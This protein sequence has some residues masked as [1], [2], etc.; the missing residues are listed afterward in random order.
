MAWRRMLAAAIAAGS[1]LVAAP[2]AMAVVPVVTANMP[3]D[4]A[5]KSATL[6]GRVDPSSLQ[7]TY[8]FEWDVAG[9]DFCNSSPTATAAMRGADGIVE[10]YDGPTSV[11]ETVANLSPETTYCFRVVAHN[12]SGTSMSSRVNF[13][14]PPMPPETALFKKPAGL[15]TTRTVEMGFNS[16]IDGVTF[17]CRTDGA[18]WNACAS[19]FQLT[20]LA[21][22]VHTFEVR[23]I[24][25]RTHL[26]D[27]TPATSTFRVSAGSGTTAGGA[28]GG[29]GTPGTVPPGPTGS[30]PAPVAAAP[31]VGRAG[32][33][34]LKGAKLTTGQKVSC[35]GTGEACRV[36]VKLTGSARGSKKLAKIGAARMTVAAGAS[37]AVVVKL[38][39]K[40]RKLLKKAHALKV[41][42]LV[43]VR[44]GQRIP[45]TAGMKLNVKKK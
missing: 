26:E 3:Q 31:K 4:L 20:D 21:D 17:E 44:R 11:T 32:R 27:E 9:S 38:N 2:A 24:D 12:A 7:T 29:S 1:T 8:H 15:V 30:A 19:P 43:T 22:G 16:S 18:A 33:A 40:G 28:G 36:T 37:K 42:S 39:A 41:V 5:A 45:V 14:T 10:A 25:P 23:A 6:L 35:A 13:T 34:K